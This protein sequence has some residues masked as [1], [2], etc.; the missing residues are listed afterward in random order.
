ML[1]EI[2][3]DCK[4]LQKVILQSV[5]RQVV[6]SSPTWGVFLFQRVL[7]LFFNANF[8]LKIAKCRKIVV[9]KNKKLQK[10]T[11]KYKKMMLPAKTTSKET[12][13]H[14]KQTDKIK[15][16][17]KTNST[18]SILQK[19]SRKMFNFNCPTV[20]IKQIIC[21]ILSDNFL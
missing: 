17:D 18:S 12:Y 2:K 3:T 7:A 13:L 1:F 21:S 9:I 15:L 10:I 19:L 6:G 4:K 14:Y 5:N 20:Q 11:K 8:W 16:S